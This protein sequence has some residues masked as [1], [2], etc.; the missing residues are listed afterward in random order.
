[1]SAQELTALLLLSAAT[2]FTPGPNTT[3]STALAA[4]L[5][6]R[7]A[8]R[9]VLA[10]PVG[11]GMLLGLCMAGVGNLVLTWP[12]LRFVILAGGAAYL[13]WLAWRLSG[14]R[15]L[16]Q[17]DT[18]RLQ[19]GFWQGVGLQFL[20]IKAWML[21]LSLVAGW[22]AGKE[23]AM[24][25]SMML[26]PIMMA[27]GFFSNLTYALVGSL[28]RDWLGQGQRLLIFNRC[29]AAALLLTAAWMLQSAA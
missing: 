21:A 6:L 10:V 29:M 28:L 4:N 5:G 3:L 1:M 14:T 27:F 8:L 17:A 23:D 15:E 20:N 22:I 2:S 18:Q 11:W 12:M 7:S 9:F 13:V 16:L 26:L 25:R 24:A 19:I